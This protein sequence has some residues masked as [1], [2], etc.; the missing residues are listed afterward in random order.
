MCLIFGIKCQGIVEGLKHFVDVRVANEIS[1]IHHVSPYLR[2]GAAAVDGKGIRLVY[3]RMPMAVVHWLEQ[4]V[5]APYLLPQ[6][7]PHGFH[8]AVR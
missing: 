5:L 8:L 3:Q 6:I 4:G 7:P 2:P 1:T